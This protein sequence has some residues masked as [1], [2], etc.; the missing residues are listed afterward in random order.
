MRI[1]RSLLLGLGA[2]L[3]LVGVA[4][5]VAR[6]WSGGPVSVPAGQSTPPQQAGA[7]QGS[8]DRTIETLQSRLTRTPAEPG[9]L[10][11]L[12]L[13]YLQKARETADPTYY[14][15]A[16]QALGQA[17][18]LAPQHPDALQG[19]GTLALARHQFEDAL[20]YGRR[21]VAANPGRAAGWGIIGDALVELGRYEEAV[22]AVQ[23]MVDTRPD[24]SSYARVSHLRELHGDLPGAVEAMER[25]VRAGAPATENTA[26]VRVQLANLLVTAGRVEEAE[27]HYRATLAV[28]PGYAP[29]LGG[30]ARVNAARGND[31]EAERL[32]T[33]A[34]AGF[35]APEHVIALGELYSRHGRQVEAERQFGLVRAI[36]RLYQE[37][38]MEIDVELALFES[39]HGDPEAA[40]RLAEAGYARRPNIHAAGALAWA[41]HRAGRTD[42]ARPYLD[43][44]QRLGTQDPILLARA[45]AIRGQAAGDGGEA[46]RS[47]RPALGA[48][49]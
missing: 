3:A 27:R 6:P 23:R 34:V 37:S 31:A 15:R 48:N 13:A 19:M 29:A 33:Q 36:M 2:A 26:Y 47:R 22:A 20:A 1:R 8:T 49:R 7:W 25:A 17:L 9:L 10:A 24:L 30:L 39:D 40:V 4:L 43:E 21:V 42:E 46:L 32:L 35:P 18:A 44:A 11:Q 38:G 16:E 12:G 5:T 28:I 41:L 14:H 45:A